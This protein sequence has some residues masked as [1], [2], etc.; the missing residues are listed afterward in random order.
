MSISFFLTPTLHGYIMW[1]HVSEWVSYINWSLLW[2]WWSAHKTAIQQQSRFEH[3]TG[4]HQPKEKV[5]KN[6]SGITFTLFVFSLI[7]DS[8]FCNGRS[9]VAWV[10]RISLWLSGFLSIPKTKSP[11]GENSEP[12]HSRNKNT[13][14]YTDWTYR[15]KYIMRLTNNVFGISIWSNFHLDSPNIDITTQRPEMRLV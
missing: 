9:S 10:R 14:M 6:E 8:L 11:R 4:G 12:E 7:I 3:I 1:T 5:K 13:S 15:S 2:G